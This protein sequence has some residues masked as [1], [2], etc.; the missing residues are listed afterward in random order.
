MASPI[1]TENSP[2][3]AMN[4]LVPSSGSTNQQRRL[5]SAS[6]QVDALLGDDAVVGKAL[7]AAR[8][9]VGVGELIGLGD[10]IVLALVRDREVRA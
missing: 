8:H 5:L 9:D 10:R 3:L 2:F 1:I 6:P 4:S 7:R